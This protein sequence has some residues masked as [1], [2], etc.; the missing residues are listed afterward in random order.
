[1]AIP[2]GGCTA[3]L[4]IN[5][6]V[7]SKS[8]EGEMSMSKQLRIFFDFSCPY[9]YLAWGYFK[10]VKENKVL[11]DDWVGWEIHP[12]V[13]KEGSAIG[14]VLQGVNMEERRLKLNTLGAPV[15]LTPAD[16]VFVPNTRWA[17]CAV[18]FARENQKLHAWMEAVFH[19]SF[20]E[21]KNIGDL[22]VLLAIAGKIGLDAAA[23]RQVLESGRYLGVLL[24]HDQECV[25]RKVEWVP[26]VFQGEQKIIEGAFTYDEFEKV[27]NEKI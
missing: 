18:E 1:M 4:D 20:A 16:K 26:T 11:N 13:P 10:K 6:K 14:D 24:A 12:D 23:L 7:H 19:A 25:D 2:T 21:Q 17:L 22:E 5:K 8:G 9:C 3:A 15:G 27:M